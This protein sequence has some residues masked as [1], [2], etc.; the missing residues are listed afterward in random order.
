MEI[1]P[2]ATVVVLRPASSHPFDVLMV[3]RSDKVVFMAGAY[4]FPGGRV[5]DTDAP[6]PADACDGLD[7]T[8][9]YADLAPD[10]EARHRVAA[11]RE[12]LEEAGVLMARR[13]G[14][15]VDAATAARV[16]AALGAG[17]PLV[18]LLAAHGLSAALDAV[19]PFAHWVTPDAEVRRFDTRFLLAR[20]PDA[21]EASHDAG[22][23]TALEWLAPDAAIVRARAGDIALPPPTWITLARLAAFA[24]VDDA[25]Q[26]A[27]RTS[28]V[29]I[30][31][32]FV[33]SGESTTL[34][35]P[36]DPAYPLP[37]GCEP[38]AETR[39]HFGGG[40]WQPVRPAGV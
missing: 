37:P 18:P 31:P 26:W 34:M 33:R 39:F 11:I 4:V 30:E 27:S 13:D 16:R 14:R 1:R 2:A 8:G 24:S 23:T 28:I 20:M 32:G 10:D 35:L 3:R 21:Q 22:E 19:M 25:W 12:L 38:L 7:A 15:L 9:R 40:T 6:S 29:R 36:G 17:T 5:D